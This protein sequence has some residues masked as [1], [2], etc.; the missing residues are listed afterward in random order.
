MT[1][2]QQIQKPRLDM[3]QTEMY[4][5]SAFIPGWRGQALSPRHTPQ[6]R[7]FWRKAFTPVPAIHSRPTLQPVPRLA[8]ECPIC[9]ITLTTRRIS[10]R[11]S[12]R[13]EAVQ[14]GPRVFSR[15]GRGFLPLTLRTPILRHPQ[16]RASLVQD[17][18]PDHR[19]STTHRGGTRAPGGR[20]FGGM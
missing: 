16:M 5:T 1:M 19:T 18:L 15:M 14:V 3:F 2:T 20:R 8:S 17:D 13:A 12:N 4:V 9:R 11:V 10:H 7:R 6:H